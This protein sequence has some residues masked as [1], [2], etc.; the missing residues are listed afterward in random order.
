VALTKIV[1]GVSP[2][3]ASFEDGVS[4]HVLMNPTASTADIVATWGENQNRRFL[5]AAWISGCD[6]SAPTLFN[7]TGSSSNLSSTSSTI[8]S[9]PDNSLMIDGLTCDD[10]TS[11]SIATTETDQTQKS[12]MDQSFVRFRASERPVA[13]GGNLAM[14]WSISGSTRS[15]HAA[16]AFEAP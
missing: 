16:L 14:G 2:Q 1:G 7:S 8:N 9:V 15:A 6:S 13:T 10:A 4:I 3:E 11:G 12:T 5:A